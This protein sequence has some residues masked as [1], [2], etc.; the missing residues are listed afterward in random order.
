MWGLGG[1]DEEDWAQGGGGTG[2]WAHVLACGGF[3]MGWGTFWGRALSGALYALHRFLFAR[4]SY[5]K[6]ALRFIGLV[7]RSGCSLSK[8][9][10]L[11]CMR[12][13]KGL[14]PAL[15]LLTCMPFPY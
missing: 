10:F 12:L 15:L 11:S 7:L 5:L 8:L 1:A 6:H 4:A 3:S 14:C 9:Q 13:K 2:S